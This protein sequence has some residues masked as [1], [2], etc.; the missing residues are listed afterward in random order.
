MAD[1]DKIAADW[2]VEIWRGGVNAWECDE[3]GHLN[4]RFYIT[5]VLEGLTVLFAMAGRPAQFGAAEGGDIDIVEMH[6][7][8]HREARQATPLHMHGAFTRIDGDRAEVAVVIWHSLEGMVAATFRAVIRHRHGWGAGFAPDAAL[9]AQTPREAEGRSASTLPVSGGKRDLPH[10]QRIAMGAVTPADCDASGRMSVHKVI[11]AV[12]DGVKQLTGPLRDVVVANVDPK[13]TRIGG[14]V[15][16]TRTVHFR[17]PPAGAAFEVRSGLCASD[18][19]TFTLEHWVLCPVSGETF[20]YSEAH[21]VVF[22]LDARRIVPI[23]PAATAEL[24]AFTRPSA[25]FPDGRG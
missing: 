6:G 14:A 12:S 15:L 10:Y 24:I 13:P 18:S 20:A 21:A 23:T 19:R 8:Y 22:D 16:E 3:M 4:T 11:A 25:A 17:L 9:M 7:R 1:T 5:R 2:G